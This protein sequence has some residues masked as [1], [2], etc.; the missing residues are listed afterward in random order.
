M[1][2][3]GDFVKISNHTSSSRDLAGKHAQVVEIYPH[4]GQICV[5]VIVPIREGLDNHPDFEVWYHVFN[6]SYLEKAEDR[7]PYIYAYDFFRGKSMAESRS[8]AAEKIRKYLHSPYNAKDVAERQHQLYIRFF[9]DLYVAEETL[10]E[11][12]KKFKEENYKFVRK[13]K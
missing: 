1:F 4:S 2:A 13:F 9:A 11:E 7:Y 6:P 12:Y 5:E 8:D 10:Y 3:V